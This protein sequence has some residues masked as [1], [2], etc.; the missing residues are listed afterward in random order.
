MELG[1]LD[2]AAMG[3]DEL[4]QVGLVFGWV[5]VKCFVCSLLEGGRGCS[6]DRVD[7][8]TRMAVGT[9]SCMLLDSA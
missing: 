4:L 8:I 6:A 3:G 2:M 7:A 1:C 9:E 5:L